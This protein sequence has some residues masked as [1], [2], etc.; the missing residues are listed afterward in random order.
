M[1]ATMDGGNRQWQRR[2]T[3][4][5]CSSCDFT[6][7]PALCSSF[8]DT[9]GASVFQMIDPQVDFHLGREPPPQSML[10]GSQA[11]AWTWPSK[12]PPCRGH[13]W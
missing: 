12:H 4:A 6:D 13:G 5:T 3:V 9:L 11:K 8:P 1:A 10:T 2:R 7:Q